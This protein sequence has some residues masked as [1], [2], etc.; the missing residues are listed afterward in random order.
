MAQR[1]SK[2]EVS[3]QFL[4]CPLFLSI[5]TYEGCTFGCRYC[6]V[7]RQYARQ[8]RGFEGRKKIRPALIS[9]WEK[10]LNGQGIGSPM[11]EYL[12]RE[13]H[14]IQLGANA[15]PFPRG[16]EGMVGNTRRFLETCNE[17]KYPV[18]ITTKNTTDLPIDLLA[19]GNYVLG[20]SLASHRPRDT[21]FL[22]GNTSL[23][24]ERLRRIPKGVFRK[25]VVRWQPFIPGLFKAKRGVG[26]FDLSAVDRFLDLVAEAAEAVS[27]SHLNWGGITEPEVLEYVGQD[28]V[29]DL[30]AL[31]LFT[32][33]R[34]G[35]HQRGLEFY[36]S[37]YRA[38][39][40]SPI[41]CGLRGDEFKVSTR[42]V[43]AFLIWKLFSGEREYLT[44][45]DIKEAFP[46]EL[47]DVLFSTLDVALFSRWARYSAKR[48]TILEEYIRNFTRDR[49][50]NP[51]NFFAGMYSQVVDGEYR[52]YFMDYRATVDRP[53]RKRGVM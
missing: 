24:R 26:L 21:G 19:E 35:A 51:A 8:N 25:V 29:G 49:R 42:W 34:Q 50:M 27:I 10:V 47:K 33:I 11:I 37:N 36:T 1:R 9:S 40:D 18:Y 28:D 15:E 13:R 53:Q 46:D 16:V 43:W 12:V 38:L 7:N 5:D 44:V 14:L 30:D 31:E 52:I 39:S 22:E 17:A 45:E 2:L 3:G 20:V 48:T 23:P 41:C 6:F 32:Y 4:H